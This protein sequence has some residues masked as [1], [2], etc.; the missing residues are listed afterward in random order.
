MDELTNIWQKFLQQSHQEENW[1]ERKKA[2]YKQRNAKIKRINVQGKMRDQ[3]NSEKINNYAYDLY[4]ALNIQQGD[5]HYTEELLVPYQFDMTEGTITN[6]TAVTPPKA[7]QAITVMKM[8][9]VK[10][11]ANGFSYNREAAVAYANKW[12][13]AYN[14]KY[15]TFR[16]DCTN[17]ISQCLFAGGAPMRGSPV[18][19]E[20]WWYTGGMWSF[21]WSVAH[22][23]RWYLS[24]S[25]EGLTASEVD[26]AKEL[27]PGDIIC[28]DFE[29]DERWD[30]NTIVVAKDKDN[31]PLVNAHTDNSRNR[32]WTYEDSLAWTNR[33]AYTFFRIGE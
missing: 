33:T 20:G 18:R 19:E 13:N 12:W 1:W 25:N 10:S 2:R 26:S 32:Y 8:N 15:E 23:L 27:M 30:H 3:T 22:S 14:P 31:M 29:G 28:Y 16:V 6:H 17:Y 5:F 21:S 9:D 11:S 4:V 24:T 7:E